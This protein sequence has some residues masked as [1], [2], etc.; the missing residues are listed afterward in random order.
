[1]ESHRTSSPWDYGEDYYKEIFHIMTM[2]RT[3]HRKHFPSLGVYVNNVA[4]AP[5]G[6][7][8]IIQR[9]CFHV[10]RSVM[11]KAILESVS[12]AVLM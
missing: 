2:G 6:P 11:M 8:E 10:Q 4:I 7:P 5:E 12:P 3:I 9:P 1:M